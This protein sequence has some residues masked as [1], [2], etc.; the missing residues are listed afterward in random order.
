V[1]YCN[2]TWA[3]GDTETKNISDRNENFKE[4]ID[5]SRLYVIREGESTNDLQDNKMVDNSLDHYGII[6]EGLT[7][8]QINENES[9]ADKGDGT[10]KVYSSSF[11][12]WH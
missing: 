9:I 4:F 3:W 7:R 1:K 11:Y 12:S 5:R 8:V 10:V 2:H 6:Y